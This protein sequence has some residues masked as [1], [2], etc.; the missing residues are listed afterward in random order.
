MLILLA[1]APCS[2]HAADRSWS[3]SSFLDFIGGEL[4]DG[5]VN[6][7]VTADG[8]VR[9][10]N[11]WDLNND[12][13]FDLP[14]ACAQ[15]HDE[16]T[17]AFVYWAEQDG[18]SPKRRSEIPTDG[19]IGAAAAD[20]NFDG[21]VDLVLVN[22]FD[23]NTTELDGY[24][25]W[26]SRDGFD[27]ARRT[28]LP[29]RAT[30]AVAIA[31]LNGDGYLEIVFANQGVDYHMT[32]DNFQRS[33]IY[34]GSKH[35]YSSDRRSELPTVNCSDVVIADV[36]QDT[37][38]DI[39]FTNEGNDESQSGVVIYLGDSHGRFAD[40]RT[41]QLPGIYPAGACVTDLNADGF[42]D[43]AM[44][45]MY[46]LAGKPDPPNG[47]KVETFR[48]NSYIYWGGRD[49]FS[50]KHRTELPTLGS[51]AVAAGDLNGDHLPEVVFANSAASQST[52]YW[53]GPAGFSAE[54]RTAIA[55]EQAHDVAIADLD[56]NGHADLIFA[57]YASSGFFDTSSFIYWGTPD[58]FHKQDRTE[59]PT[60]GASAIV[61][62]DLNGD[63]RTDIVF[64]N[65]IEGVSYPGGTTTAVADVGPTKSFVY[66]G[67]RN[68][69]FDAARRQC[70]PTVR[71]ADGHLNS[72]LN[73]DGFVDL[74]FAHFGSP[75]II[76]W[77]GP[78]GF[79][80][81]N[82]TPL[83]YG[84]AATARTADFDRDGYLD[85]LLEH[86]I[87]FGQQSGFSAENR[88]EF[89]T[90]GM[91]PSLAD[92]NRDG[93]LDVIAP[94]KNRV[95]I[96]WNGP[97]G[98]NHRHK[99]ELSLPG[100]RC[101]N[102]EP[103]DLNR[104]RFLD[105]IAVN[106][107]DY[108]K[109]LGPGEVAVLHGNPNVDASVF[110]G[111]E[112]GYSEQQQLRLPTIGPTDTVAADF[113]A[114]GYVDIFFPSYFGGL[115][116]S[117]PGRLYWNGPDGFDAQRRTEIP[118]HSGCGVLAADCNLDG[119]PELIVANHTIVGN[120]R[121]PLWI[122]WGSA[123]GFRASQRTPLPATGVHFFSLVDIGNVY[124]RSD[125]Y[126]YISSAFDAGP[127]GKVKSSILGGGD[128]ISHAGQ[129]TD[130]R[131]SDKNRFGLRRLVRRERPE[132]LL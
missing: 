130:S 6:T 116:R 87:F 82:K 83:P 51:F 55:A 33:F 2:V 69:Q 106:I 129:T 32:V 18:Y 52:I 111:S 50:T 91:K 104:D 85:L 94:L 43:V 56:L 100:K 4:G 123:Q 93:W 24:I 47:N 102:V 27:T 44:A 29:G 25:C 84:E 126:D 124:D 59:L 45:N 90:G 42:V 72:D 58:G 105:L 3:T 46:R 21:H 28:N 61:V 49:G 96:Y 48:V 92:L 13:N 110:W 26:G 66:W 99:V 67:D 8:T 108:G 5:G 88:F 38:P 107:L 70:L 112:N 10:I 114:D 11:L 16:E 39:V 75:T 74:L 68:G 36:N 22:R 35:G 117:F 115:H 109:P 57:N 41:I 63:R 19:A 20:L 37:Y 73:A 125:E 65:K 86:S 89:D 23:G 12:G 30:K 64:V 97:S 127:P 9:L 121:S 128:A 98:F 81:Q 132:Q 77:N 62:E 103:A 53:N 15:D 120:H 113:N 119:Y 14:I 131:G 118:G 78:A 60:S 7:Y 95:A 31:D 54:R 76:Y 34:W 40:D 122:H 17:D 79:D 101:V 80:P 71:N 1:L